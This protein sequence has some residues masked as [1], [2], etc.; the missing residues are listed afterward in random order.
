MGHTTR[1]TKLVRSNVPTWLLISI[2]RAGASAQQ[3]LSYEASTVL[4]TST[5]HALVF[6][7]SRRAAVASLQPW[8]NREAH[9]TLRRPVVQFGA[10]VIRRPTV[11]IEALVGLHRNALKRFVAELN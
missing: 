10:L 5:T 7:R 4:A 6:S 11:K 8:C 1:S 2:P 3:A 9:A